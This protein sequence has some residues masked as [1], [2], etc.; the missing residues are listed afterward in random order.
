[1]SQ[2]I[3]TYKGLLKALEGL[4]VTSLRELLS[5]EIFV[6]QQFPEQ[7]RDCE[8]LSNFRLPGVVEVD[9]NRL[10]SVVAQIGSRL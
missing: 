10:E 6:G 3:G 2:R 9:T 5:L 1:M 4:V 8:S 7:A